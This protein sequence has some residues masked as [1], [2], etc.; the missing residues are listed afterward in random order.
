MHNILLAI[1]GLKRHLDPAGYDEINTISFM[2]RIKNNGL[3]TVKLGFLTGEQR[4]FLAFAQRW[5]KF[6]SEAAL[7]KQIA[8]DTHS[9]GEYRSNNVRNLDAWYKAYQVAPTDKLFLAP[10]ARL[11]V[12]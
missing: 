3:F 2:V 10:E 12:W 8:T 5:R 6:Q 1:I 7:R 4:F 9:P 11:T